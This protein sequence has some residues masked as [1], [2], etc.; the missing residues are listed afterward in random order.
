MPVA[1]AGFCWGGLHA[2]RL[3]HDRPDAKTAK[4]QPLADAF[5][6][7]HASSVEFPHDIE[8]VKLNLS[9]ANGDDDGVMNLQQVQQLQK[10]LKS[11]E[12]V[13]TEIVI[14]PGAKHGFAVRASR[15]VPDSQETKQAEE[16]EKQA[17]AW[18]QRQF[19]IVK[20]KS[21]R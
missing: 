9:Y 8:K 12:E 7:A 2:I 16:A 1:I 6:S 5:F 18:F 13:D 10:I 17:I 11:K 15:A 3:T 20:Q 21:S 4:G 14:Y 19:E